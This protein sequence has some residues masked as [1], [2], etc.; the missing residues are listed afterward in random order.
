MTLAF[1]P[2]VNCLIACLTLLIGSPLWAGGQE[3]TPGPAGFGEK[4]ARIDPL[5]KVPPEARGKTEKGFV[6]LREG[7]YWRDVSRIV[8]DLNKKEIFYDL[9][10]YRSA[11]T[12]GHRDLS[13]EKANR[14]ISLCNKIWSNPKD[15]AEKP[16]QPF[17]V[18]IEYMT[19]LVLVDDGSYRVISFSTAPL[20][21]F[22]QLYQMVS[23]LVE[24]RE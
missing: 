9:Y 21:E 18:G 8:V 7:R 1:R 15:N 2:F 13:Q 6:I 23:D 10:H 19:S 4:R 3:G 5:E 14:M 12:Q 11:P 17:L 16:N 22:E 24:K 20:R